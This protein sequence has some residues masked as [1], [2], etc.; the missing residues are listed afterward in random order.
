MDHRDPHLTDDLE[1]LRKEYRLLSE[2]EEELRVIHDFAV[3]LLRQETLHDVV[4]AIARNAIAK[5][6]FVDCV[7]YLMN[8]SGN[9]LTQVAAHGPKNPQ[10]MDIL[11]PIIIPVGKGIVGTVALS[12]TPELIGDTS[13]DARYIL[14]DDFRYSEI[15]VPILNGS[16]VIGVID[17]EHPDKDFFTPQH[18][19]LLTTIAAMATSKILHTKAIEQLKTHQ[20]GLKATIAIQTAELKQNISQLQLINQDLESFAYAASH[21][22]AEPLRSIASFLQL[23]DRNEK[24]LSP[25][26]Q[27]Y[28]NFAIQGAH[29]MRSLLDGLLV[30]SRLGQKE[31]DF[32]I[33]Q[34]ELIIDEVRSNLQKLI[35]DKEATIEYST[36]HP[37][38]GNTTGILQLLQNLISNAI[39]FHHRERKPLIRITQQEEANVF[40]FVLEDNGIGME[41]IFLDKAFRLFGRLHT[42]REYQGSGIGLAICKRIVEHHGGRIW[43]KSKPEA[44]TQVFFTIQKS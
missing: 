28:M 41:E 19:R 40:L 2:R 9:A 3:T 14:D 34:P 6:G 7:I 10:E 36:M 38:R 25:S 42:T 4:W 23:I 5:L 35:A 11:N 29:R 18:L 33:I 27:E 1:Q 26:S 31:Q 24:S 20:E 16:Q 37:I 21:D 43:I 12:R 39:K 22:L 13:Q 30:Y 32:D 8:E 17:S 15:A 44:G